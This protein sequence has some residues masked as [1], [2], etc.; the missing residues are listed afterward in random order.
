MSITKLEDDAQKYISSS[1]FSS[2]GSAKGIA[3]ERFKIIQ[4]LKYMLCC[5]QAKGYARGY[6]RYKWYD[7]HTYFQYIPYLLDLWCIFE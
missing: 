6:A 2:K 7:M 1:K 4:I 3:K 5:R